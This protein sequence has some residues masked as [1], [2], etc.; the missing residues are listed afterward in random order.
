MTLK[1]TKFRWQQLRI[2]HLSLWE[3]PGR[4]T[5]HL[6]RQQKIIS[7]LGYGSKFST[8][9][10]LYSRFTIQFQFMTAPEIHFECAGAVRLLAPLRPDRGVSG[11]LGDRRPGAPLGG[12]DRR[13]HH[14][15]SR[16]AKGRSPGGFSAQFQFV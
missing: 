11:G 6:I 4:L 15:R 12:M 13:G 16:E 14:C 5:R 1:T 9:L 7:S 10:L 2:S 8:L 3:R